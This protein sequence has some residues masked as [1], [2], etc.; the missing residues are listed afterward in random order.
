MILKLTRKAFNRKL[1]AFVSSVLLS[2]ALTTTGFTSFIVS[3]NAESQNE[4]NVQVAQI[5]EGSLQ[6][7]NLVISG[8]GNLL[9]EPAVDDDSGR[10]RGDG[11][12]YEYLT[13]TITG[14][15]K[16][17]EYLDYIGLE[18]I[19]PQGA[20]DAVEAGY[21]VAPECANKEVVV[22]KRSDYTATATGEISFAYTFKFGWGKMFNNLNPSIFFDTDD[23]MAKYSDDEMKTILQDFR[24]MVYGIEDPDL[25]FDELPEGS[26]IYTIKLVAYAN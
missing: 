24:K 22:G 13:I 8:D 1:I 11:K 10:I 12:N 15:L 17:S 5:A 18:L 7:V 16:H 2:V 20:M 26:N 19:M 21:I 4:G 14:R 23:G 25:S 3:T 6:F 9:F